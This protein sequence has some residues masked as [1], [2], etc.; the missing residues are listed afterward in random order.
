MAAHVE[1]FRAEQLPQR[2]EDASLVA[3]LAR[4]REPS[5][6]QPFST[7]ALQAE[8]FLE[9]VGQEAIPW[10]AAWML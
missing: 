6:E 9:T 8:L 7:Q 5:S 10:T 2:P 3:C 4:L 1:R